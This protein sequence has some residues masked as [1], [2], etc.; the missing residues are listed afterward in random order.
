MHLIKIY[1]A[2]DALPAEIHYYIHKVMLMS[3]KTDLEKEHYKF[4][5]ECAVE[6]YPIVK[7]ELEEGKIPFVNLKLNS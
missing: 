3:V 5:I 4:Y 6:A 1:L 7:T 2:Y